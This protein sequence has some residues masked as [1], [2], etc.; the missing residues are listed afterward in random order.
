MA[1]CICSNGWESAGCPVHGLR[2]WRP[3]KDGTPAEPPARSRAS[4]LSHRDRH[5]GRSE[6][7]VEAPPSPRDVP[8]WRSGRRSKPGV[9]DR[10]RTS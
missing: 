8:G 6:G 3:L 4:S 5:A 7:D 10:N 1:F 2:D 9:K